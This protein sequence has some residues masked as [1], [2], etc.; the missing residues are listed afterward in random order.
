MS[1]LDTAS[2][3]VTPNGYKE[4]KLYSVIPSD[5]SGDM[6]VVRATTATRVN[7][8]GLVELVP[9]NLFSYSEQFTNA[10][11]LKAASGGVSLPT[12]T[13]NTTIAPNGTTT[14]DTIVFPAVSGSQFSFIYNE[15]GVV[16]S[17]TTS[18]Y[19]KGALGGEIIW[20]SWTNDGVNYLRKQLT[21]TT[22]WERYD[23]TANVPATNQGVIFG[24]DLRDSQQSAKPS[25]TIYAWG[26]Q[27]VEGS[28]AK[29]YQKTETR[30]N[31]PRLDYS[32][33]TCPS[34][35]VEP[36]R[37]NLLTYS[38]SFDNS[39]WVKSNA[40]ISANTIASPSAIQDAD[41]IIEN[42]A[43]GI[44][45]FY[46][47]P[48][49][50]SSGIYTTSMF[51][52][53][54]TRQYAFLQIAVN[55]AADRFTAVIDLNNG[56]VTDTTTVGS[57]TSTSY[58]TEDF[59]NGWYRLTV[60]AQHNS[61]NVFLVSGLSDS[62]TPTYN[63]TGEPNY[64]GN[65]T[66]SVYAWGAQIE[67]GN[68]STS[69]IPTTS[70]SVTRNADVISKTG[71]SSLIG[72]TEGSVFLDLYAT[73]QNSDSNP[74]FSLLASVGNTNRVEIYTNN[75]VLG[76]IIYSPSA[77][78]VLSTYTIVPN[79]RIR[80]ALA[81]QSGATSLFVNG[82][83]VASSAVTFSLSGLNDFILNKSL[84]GDLQAENSYNA[85]ALWKTRLTNDE[86]ERLTGTGFNT[87]A[88]MA[89]YYNYIT[90]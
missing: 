63:V 23:Y 6:S 1:L 29:D 83:Q 76:F 73:G 19:L 7:S 10:Y 85:A 12:I 61:G 81:Y 8:A 26:A 40:T 88:E 20:I 45:I 27:L 35:L 53:K 54:N 50:A 64:T 65:G 55:G 39:D 9:Y 16:G 3:I 13:E 15:P 11:W 71:I 36:Q 41:S 72:Q 58:T 4:G 62:A 17:Y 68:Y 46:Q 66:G 87:Y 56:N 78:V 14:A 34:L 47:G 49:A 30:L 31:I 90:Q 24:I 21:L 77:T 38:S 52:K 25:Q 69:F 37:T 22:S 79:E 60:S 51:F 5:G 44:H 75:G 70:A 74:G 28:T 89:N 18:I 82:A 48:I 84:I 43:T 86:L 57:P 59:G 80:V 67:A 42:T 2:L 33:G 32:N